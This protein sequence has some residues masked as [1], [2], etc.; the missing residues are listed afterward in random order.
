MS[1]E[2]RVLAAFPAPPR[3]IYGLSLCQRTGLPAGTIYP[4]LVRLEQAG[5]VESYWE[6]PAAHEPSGRTG[7]SGVA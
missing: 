1:A 7:V 3:D 2:R 5:W 4:I 6:A